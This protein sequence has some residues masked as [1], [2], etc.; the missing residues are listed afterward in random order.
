MVSAVEIFHSHR[1]GNVSYTQFQ[2]HL[3][4]FIY[5]TNSISFCKTEQQD[6][7]D[8]RGAINLLFS[9]IYFDLIRFPSPVF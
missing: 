3:G 1:C 7:E 9:R 5:T 8:L 6:Y 2:S 4:L